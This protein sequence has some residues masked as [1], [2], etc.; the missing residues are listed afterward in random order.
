MGCEKTTAVTAGILCS[1]A[2]ANE[3]DIFP[4]K[5][6]QGCTLCS[7]TWVKSKSILFHL[8][9]ALGSWFIIQTSSKQTCTPIVFAWDTGGPY[10]QHKETCGVSIRKNVHVCNS[11]PKFYT[12]LGRK[13]NRTHLYQFAEK[14]L[15]SSILRDIFT[16]RVVRA[17]A[18]A[19][20]HHCASTIAD[21]PNSV[22]ATTAWR[23][24]GLLAKTCLCPWCTS[25]M[26]G[27][28]QHLL[29]VEHKEKS[30]VHLSI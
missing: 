5:R 23:T 19:H 16:V 29:R 4:S 18:A 15:Q 17:F 25:R 10:I 3:W 12:V 8:L 6:E 2:T 30:Q 22:D 28:D 13:V 9:W 24:H 27:L 14:E 21:K 20:H 11:K 26:S 1:K 7:S